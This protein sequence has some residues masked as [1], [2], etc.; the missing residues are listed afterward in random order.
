MLGLDGVGCQRRLR[1]ILQILSDDDIAAAHDGGG[2]YMPVIGIGKLERLDQ[3]LITRDETVPRCR[4]HEVA[5]PLQSRPLGR[6]LPAHQRRDPLT[7]N[8][9]APFG[10][11]QVSDRQLHEQVAKR[12]RVEHICVEQRGVMAHKVQ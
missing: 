11:T 10:L 2:E 3:L 9:R 7:V 1:E 4:V 12:G 5:G 8:V 6:R